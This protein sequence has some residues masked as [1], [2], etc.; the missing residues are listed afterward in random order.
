MYVALGYLGVGVQR[1]FIGYQRVFWG[2]IREFVMGDN[3]GLVFCGHGVVLGFLCGLMCVFYLK[4]GG[5]QW[6]SLKM[7]VTRCYG[8]IFILAI[9]SGLSSV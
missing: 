4:D 1:Y 3:L 7:T 6:Y 2:F 8:R 9:R 5:A